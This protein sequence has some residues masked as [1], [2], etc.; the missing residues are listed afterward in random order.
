MAP[1]LLRSSASFC[2]ACG[3]FVPPRKTLFCS[4]GL[5]ETMLVVK[6][7]AAVLAPTSPSLQPFAR[8]A[9]TDRKTLSCP[10]WNTAPLHLVLPLLLLL[11]TLLLNTS[12]IE[13]SF[14]RQAHF[15]TTAATNPQIN[16]AAGLISPLM[17]SACWGELLFIDPAYTKLIIYDA[18][19]VKSAPTIQKKTS[20]VSFRSL[21]HDRVETH[22][23]NQL[24]L[25]TPHMDPTQHGR[26]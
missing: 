17:V 20:S 16:T 21:I 4:F 14:F 1:I 7:S 24:Q 23:H 26:H 13:P 19:Q 5:V 2:R 25:D 8:S 11:R 15:L 12:E 9:D 18:W 6:S 22:V 3:A 10:F